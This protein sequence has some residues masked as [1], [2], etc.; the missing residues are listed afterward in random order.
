M[1]DF[2]N[3]PMPFNQA[4]KFFTKKKRR[5]FKSFSYL[6][7]EPQ[8]H[9]IAFTV[10]K[11]SGH[12]VLDT[13]YTGLQ[14][15]M[16]NNGTY[17]DFANSVTKEL[18][19][20]GWWGKRAMVDPVTGKVINA[21]LGSTRR[22]KTIFNTN[23]RSA[24]AAGEWAEM[25]KLKSEGEEVFIRYTA[26]LDGRSRPAHSEKDGVTLPMDDAFWD[27]WYPPNGWRCRCH[28]EKMLKSTMDALDIKPS[29]SPAVKK[30]LYTNSRTGEVKSVARGVD[31]SFNYNV[32][33]AWLKPY[34]PT[35]E[36]FTVIGNVPSV[37]A[38]LQ[39]PSFDLLPKNKSDEFYAMAFLR[40]F[41]VRKLDEVATFTDI[42]GTD[43]II[44][45]AL[46]T[47]AKGVLKANKN[48]RGEYMNL[49]AD[50]IQDPDRI[51]KYLS[52]DNRVRRR[53]IKNLKLNKKKIGFS[54][55]DWDIKNK[56]WIG[57]TVFHPKQ[58][59]IDKLPKGKSVYE[60]K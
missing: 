29:K 20:V 47:D 14:S 18:K 35:M 26:V 51:E 31:P 45:K 37:R 38:F 28:I 9:A 1:A 19:R 15:T 44:S 55:F 8:T 60:K 53:Y 48:N 49:L 50:T 42:A 11:T 21:Q 13:L 23:I 3:K 33:K 43:I 56:Q 58:K 46:L 5:G 27:E 4:F 2:I 6:D 40:K 24:F 25:E 22:L 39:K 12:N 30:R 10:A 7:V 34:T 32:G 17:Q 41:G 54:V 57:E 59:Y 52:I 36:G 16:A